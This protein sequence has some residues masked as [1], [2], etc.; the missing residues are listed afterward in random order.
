[1]SCST[2]VIERS[3]NALRIV[4][5]RCFVTIGTLLLGG[6]FVA[7]AMVLFASLAMAPAGAAV[8]HHGV[9]ALAMLVLMGLVMGGVGIALIRF[10]PGRYELRLDA[11]E[12]RGRLSMRTVLG[13]ERVLADFA[14]ADVR[15]VDVREEVIR[16]GYLGPWHEVALV[17][18]SEHLPFSLLGAVPLGGSQQ[19]AAKLAEAITGVL[20]ATPRADSAASAPVR[21]QQGGKLGGR[22]QAQAVGARPHP[23]VST[24]DGLAV[25]MPGRVLA[26][27]GALLSMC[28]AYYLL[29]QIAG[30]FM[31]GEI[32]VLRRSPGPRM[33]YWN[34][35]PGSFIF[36]MCVHAVLAALSGLSVWL[37]VRLARYG[38]VRTAV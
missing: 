13:R 12:K 27:L 18:V 1:M 31:Q 33:V 10:T 8:A 4:L 17:G 35:S 2:P 32:D 21:G 16:R 28:I 30:G 14:F 7:G 3:P 11:V 23:A 19:Q 5:R 25:A 29:S 9:M 20:G 24:N 34:D 38:R 26:G 37:C 22:R 15:R 36:Q 6:L